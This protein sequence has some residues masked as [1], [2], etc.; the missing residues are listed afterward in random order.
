[1]AEDNNSAT[2]ISR[3]TGYKA[4]NFNVDK[5]T[6]VRAAVQNTDGV[7]SDVVSQTYFVTTSNLAQYQ[8]LT[9]VSLVT[10]PENLFDP[11][12]GIYVTG[13]QYLDWKNSDA[14]NPDKS[15]WDTDNLTNYF[16]KG[17]EWERKAALTVFQD[18]KAVV[19]Q[20]IQ[21]KQCTEKL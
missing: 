6:V 14:Y 7:F 2:S 4:P 21:P 12:T 18:G 16:S 10:N 3:G 20:N 9:V 8:D 1:M 5:A 11:D 15:V 17:K 13:N 19:D